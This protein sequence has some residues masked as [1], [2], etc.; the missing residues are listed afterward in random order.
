MEGVARLRDLDLHAV[1]R[2]ALFV[3]KAE[4]KLPLSVFLDVALDLRVDIVGEAVE[5]RND[6]LKTVLFLHDES[7]L[8]GINFDSM[9]CLKNNRFLGVLSFF[10]RA[11]ISLYTIFDRKSWGFLHKNIEF[12]YFLH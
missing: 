4:T 5:L 3:L 7:I 9:A 11:L 8:L 1:K 10:K 6:F 2:L 12:R